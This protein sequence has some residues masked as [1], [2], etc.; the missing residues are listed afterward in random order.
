MHQTSDRPLVGEKPVILSTQELDGQEM[1][2]A[3]S[4]LVGRRL[5]VRAVGIACVLFQ[6][7][8]PHRLENLKRALN[9]E[10]FG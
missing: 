2:G 3:S 8:I 4:L 7:H 6:S 9:Y 5:Q 1:A 10:T